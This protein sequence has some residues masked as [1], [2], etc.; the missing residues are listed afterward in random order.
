M[1]GRFRRKGN[2]FQMKAAYWQYFPLMLNQYVHGL[3][4]SV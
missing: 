3:R 2:N 4:I 1:L